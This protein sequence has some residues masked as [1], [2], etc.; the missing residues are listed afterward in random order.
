MT[1]NVDCQSTMKIKEEIIHGISMNLVNSNH[2]QNIFVG[3]Y[4][5]P[6][7]LSQGQNGIMTDMTYLCVWNRFLRLLFVVIIF[8]S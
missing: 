7:K 3:I 2:W 5:T 1:C 6:V 4:L 8:L